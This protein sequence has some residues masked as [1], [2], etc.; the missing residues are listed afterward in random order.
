[1]NLIETVFVAALVDIAAAAIFF[2]IQ[3]RLEQW[4]RRKPIVVH[5]LGPILLITA[6]LLVFL[7]NYLSSVTFQFKEQVV[8]IPV[9]RFIGEDIFFPAPRIS[10]WS[11]LLIAL[12][13]MSGSLSY[14]VMTYINRS[15]R[16]DSKKVNSPH[17]EGQVLI[18]AAA[19]LSIAAYKMAASPAESFGSMRLLIFEVM[20]AVTIL[21]YSVLAKKT[22][23][24]GEHR[25]DRQLISMTWVVTLAIY[26]VA[27]IITTLV[28]WL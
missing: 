26:I 28:I 21:T 7:A 10:V 22:Q 5:S 8:R 27:W 4:Q 24:L 2:S 9:P 17:I 16:R 6:V 23:Q 11:A 3:S 1:M 12:S 25:S 18:P 13:I 20:T 15:T 19:T 14:G